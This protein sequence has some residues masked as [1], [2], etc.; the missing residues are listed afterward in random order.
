DRIRRLVGA[1]APRSRRSWLAGV[2]ALAILPT[3]LTFTVGRDAASPDSVST[4]IS[5]SRGAGESHGT[6]ESHSPGSSGS[7]SNGGS[8]S[9]SKAGSGSDS[10]EGTWS[11]KRTGDKVDLEMSMSWGGGHHL[12]S[13]GE[14]YGLKELIGLA[15]GPDVRFE[16]QRDAGTFRF[17]GKFEGD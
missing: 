8:G 13:M 14:T 4:G 6:R 10:R 5:D 2:V 17:R 12:W 11:A 7:D 16:L 3:G 15:A 1:P 9:S